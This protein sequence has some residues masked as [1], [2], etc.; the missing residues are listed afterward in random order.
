MPFTMLSENT[1]ARNFGQKNFHYG[2]YANKFNVQIQ[3]L[4]FQTSNQNNYA[5]QFF[6][7]DS[8]NGLDRRLTNHAPTDHR[9]QLCPFRIAQQ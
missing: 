3:N 9:K 8:Q 6:Q 1:P 4:K 5:D 7:T 2:N